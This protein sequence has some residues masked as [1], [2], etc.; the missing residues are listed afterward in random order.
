MAMGYECFPN[1]GITLVLWDGFVT[2]EAWRRQALKIIEDPAFPTPMVLG[3]LRTVTGHNLEKLDIFD[4]SALLAARVRALPQKLALVT[5]EEAHEQFEAF[6]AATQGLTVEI[7]RFDLL[8]MACKWLRIPC[9]ETE[10]SLDALR[11]HIRMHDA[12]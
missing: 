9:Q 6:Q 7:E 3:D 5:G 10:A 8:G 12:K 11:S 2:A 4:N 1:R